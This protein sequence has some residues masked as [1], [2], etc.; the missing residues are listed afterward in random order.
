[1]LFDNL[2]VESN[3]WVNEL[4]TMLNEGAYLTSKSIFNKALHLFSSIVKSRSNLFIE[5]ASTKQ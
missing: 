2:S 3:Q 4:S 5:P 1:M